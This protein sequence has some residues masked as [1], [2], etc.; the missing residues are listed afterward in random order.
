MI[1]AAVIAGNPYS[2]QTGFGAEAFYFNAHDNKNFN[3]KYG[4]GTFLLGL[5]A[6]YAGGANPAAGQQVVF[7]RIRFTAPSASSRYLHLLPSLGE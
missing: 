2:A 7:A 4:K 5:E 6:G 3:T 1:Y